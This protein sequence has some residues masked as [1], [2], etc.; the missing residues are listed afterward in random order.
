[1]PVDISLS[2]N[3][4]EFVGIAKKYRDA[5][6]GIPTDRLNVNLNPSDRD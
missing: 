1:M 6:D 3:V 2:A 5:N 4:G